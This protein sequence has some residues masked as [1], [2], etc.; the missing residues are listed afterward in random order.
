M[1]SDPAGRGS[2]P[3]WDVVVIGGGPAGSTAAIHLARSGHRVL[4]LEKSEFPRFHVGESLIPQDM[5]CFADLG[6]R[7]T[8][9]RLPQAKKTGVEFAMGDGSTVSRIAFDQSLVAG[10]SETFNIERAVLDQAMLD[11]ARR[12]GAEVRERAKVDSIDH[13]ADGD[14]RLT[15]AGGETVSAGYLID[16]SGQATLVGRHVKS[17]KNFCEPRYQKLAYFGH[18]EN[19]RRDNALGEDCIT[20]VMCDE[21]WFWMIPIDERRVSVGMV[22]DASVARRVKR[23][24]NQM[25]FW[26]IE[27][28]PLIRERLAEAVYP[29][30]NNVISD[31]SYSCRP[32]AGPGY[33]LIGDAAT[34]LDPVFST[35][36]YLGME[37]A[38]Q[39]AHEISAV[40]A[41]KRLPAEARRRYERFLKTGLKPFFRIIHAFYDRGF[42]DLFLN[43][44][45]P[46]SMHRAVIA[47]LCGQV[48]PRPAWSVRW[49]MRLF[50]ACMVAQRKVTLVPRRAGFSLE[51]TEAAAAS[52]KR[53]GKSGSLSASTDAVAAAV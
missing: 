41:G 4:V 44:S 13:L 39:A 51:A 19:V 22:L 33:F 24:A 2:S 10:E 21:G 37:G 32:Y 14:V 5:E 38:R 30:Q 1:S 31:Y 43:G 47:V 49:R 6:L 9:S 25:L 11:A 20:M 8:M 40:L 50:Y 52:A 28:C 46:L 48:F 29:P 17:R 16:A 53:P 18:F 27:R 35:G 3:A 42:R 45:G 12:A 36:I 7:D 34:F 26:G 23:P 15:L